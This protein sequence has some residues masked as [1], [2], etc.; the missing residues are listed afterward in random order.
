[1]HIGVDAAVAGVTRF[2]QV[3]PAWSY[4]KLENLTKAAH[5]D[6][7]DYLLTASPDSAPLRGSFEVVEAIEGYDG[8]DFRRFALRTSPKISIMKKKQQQQR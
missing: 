8:L 7:F 3:E 4:S 6:P 2:G 5:F 1:M